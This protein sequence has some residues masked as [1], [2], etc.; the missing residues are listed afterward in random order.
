MNINDL[1]LLQKAEFLNIDLIE[2]RKIKHFNG[3]YKNIDGL[4]Y[5]IENNDDIIW[6]RF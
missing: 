3:C 6:K 4:I 2:K 5:V 1:N